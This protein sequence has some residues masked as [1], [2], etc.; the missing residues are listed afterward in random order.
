M[1]LKLISSGHRD[2]QIAMKIMRTA[3]K[4]GHVA[5]IGTTMSVL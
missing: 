5:D 4:F 2:N 3:L 1:I